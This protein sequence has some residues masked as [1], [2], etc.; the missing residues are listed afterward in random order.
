MQEVRTR[1]EIWNEIVQSDS[2]TFSNSLM[3]K[4]IFS[5]VMHF[6]KVMAEL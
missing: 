1:Y 2:M 5:K 3:Q 4:V 6:I